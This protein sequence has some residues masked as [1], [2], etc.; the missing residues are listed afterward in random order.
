MAANVVDEVLGHLNQVTCAYFVAKE[1][2][3]ITGSEDQSLRLWVKRENGTGEWTC[4][5]NTS[6][7]VIIPKFVHG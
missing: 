2:V 6:R 3:F 7:Q 4:L 5:P 1:S